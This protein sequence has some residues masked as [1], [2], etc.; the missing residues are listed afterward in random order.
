M[1]F[2]FVILFQSFSH[3]QLLCSLSSTCCY[4]L[5]TPLPSFSAT[6]ISLP[7]LFQITHTTFTPTCQQNRS[8]SARFAQFPFATCLLPHHFYQHTLRPIL[9]HNFSHNRKL[10]FPRRF[11]LSTPLTTQTELLPPS[12]KIVVYCAPNIIT[13]TFT[14]NRHSVPHFDSTSTRLHST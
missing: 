14:S 9:P 12:H 10:F 13:S 11:L 6:V 1:S 7:F 5:A 3:F 2:K 8:F 4:C